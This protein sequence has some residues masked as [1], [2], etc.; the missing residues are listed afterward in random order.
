MASITLRPR[1]GIRVRLEERANARVPRDR[2]NEAKANTAWK[3][4]G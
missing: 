4:A 3:S 2:G 1:N